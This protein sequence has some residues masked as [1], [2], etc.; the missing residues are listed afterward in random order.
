MDFGGTTG[1]KSYDKW[2]INDNYN[3]IYSVVLFSVYF[4][5]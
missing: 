3:K 1:K 5:L 4:S 2:D